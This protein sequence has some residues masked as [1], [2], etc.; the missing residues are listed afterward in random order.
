VT[1]WPTLNL[2]DLAS[3]EK[4]AITD[5]PFGSHLTSAHYTDEGPLV[6]RLQNIGDGVFKHAP[7][8]ISND[9]FRSLA[10]HQVAPGDLLVASL[11]ESLPRA[12]LAP[13][14]LGPAIVK[15]DCI[16][17]RLGDAVE[18]RWVMYAL[19]RPSV[20][21]WA[22]DHLHGVGRPRLGLKLIRELPI[23]V[24]P[25]DEQRRIVD[26]LED[27]LS[28]LDAANAYL[29]AAA[30]RSRSL[31]AVELNRLAHAD[32]PQVPLA[33]LA[34][35]S[36]YGT[37]TRC[38]PEGPGLPVVR[39][40]NLRDGSVDLSD[41]KR[42]A[43][44]TVDLLTLMLTPGD[45]LI[46]RTNGSRDL[47]GRTAV[48]QPGIEASFASYLIRYR[49][50]PSRVL[51]D[52][53]HLMLNRPAARRILEGLAA[54]SAGQYNLSLGKL[55][56]VAIPLPALGEQSFR[57]AEYRSGSDA[58]ESAG[59][60]LTAARQRSESLRRLLLAAAFSGGLTGRSS[61]L[62]HAEEMAWT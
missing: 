1:I 57:M 18:P 7:A 51:P 61:D 38:V 53:V 34:I 62:D 12:C 48:V 30:R 22:R 25:L 39:I 24:P 42:A 40:P 54:S 21:R 31:T 23:P 49:L 14:D 47:I 20:R 46:V 17:V 13:A 35:S 43:D 16:R 29:H 41:E 50:D 44:P 8:H 55:D 10:K 11:G 6:V 59:Q 27:H 4:G 58:T 33:G 28:R 5:G 26:I 19:Q 9:H 37:S 3:P 15:A 2:G 32:D 56:G 52:W 60:A 36:G 45:L